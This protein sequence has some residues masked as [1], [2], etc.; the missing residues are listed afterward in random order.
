MAE[1]WAAFLLLLGLTAFGWLR[2]LPE[3]LPE[4]RP[5]HSLPLPGASEGAAL[6]FGRP[7][8]LNAATAQDIEALPGIGPARAKSIVE[9]RGA[10]GGRFSS[11]EELLDV[12]GIGERTLERL[13]PHL[14]L[15]PP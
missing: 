8:D 1:R 13:R 15:S 6:S 12:R 3:P 14:T 10:R 11:V 9:A 5:D 7:L 2:S 4:D